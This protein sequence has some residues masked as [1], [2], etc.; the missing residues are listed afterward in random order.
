MKKFHPS[1]KIEHAQ[2]YGKKKKLTATKCAQNGREF[3]FN[4]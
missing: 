2:A 3:D 4:M 1:I